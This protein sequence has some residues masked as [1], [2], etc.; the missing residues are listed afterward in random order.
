MR[1]RETVKSWVLVVVFVV[2]GV[3]ASR[4]AER[5]FGGGEARA[6]SGEQQQPQDNTDRRGM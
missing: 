4:L 2:A 6:H 1:P 3:V 5:A